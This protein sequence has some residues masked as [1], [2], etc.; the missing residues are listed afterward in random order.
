MQKELRGF[1]KYVFQKYGKIWNILFFWGIDDELPSPYFLE[2]TIDAF[3]SLYHKTVF[4]L[5][6]L[7]L[8]NLQI[9]FQFWCCLHYH[10]HLG[11]YKI[12]I[13][14]FHRHISW[15]KIRCTYFVIRSEVQMLH[16]WAPREKYGLSNSKVSNLKS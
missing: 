13:C 4:D 9:Q 14:T 3:L 10:S 6:L 12:R 8:E 11:W 16:W 5:T 7:Y 2:L 1:L 15:V